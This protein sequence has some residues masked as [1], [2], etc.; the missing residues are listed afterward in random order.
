MQPLGKIHPN[1]AKSSQIQAKIFL[2]GIGIAFLDENGTF[3]LRQELG[4]A[5]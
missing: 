2:Q 3:F 5:K 4:K 1:P